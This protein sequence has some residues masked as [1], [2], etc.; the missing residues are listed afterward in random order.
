M[1]VVPD[2]SVI[3]EK[4]LSE[5]I[6]SGKYDG[7]TIIIPEIVLSELE[8]QAN[9]GRQIGF[10]GLEEIKKLRGLEAEGKIKLEYIGERPT[11]EEI[12]LAKAGSLDAIIRDTAQ[13]QGAVLLTAD[14]VQ[15]EVANAKGISCDYV[16]PY[17]E[18]LLVSNYFSEGAQ[19]VHLK[20]GRTPKAKVGLPG[21][22]KL[23]EISGNEIPKDEINKIV[24]NINDHARV[25]GGTEMKMYGASIYQ[26]GEYR[27][28]VTQPPFSERTEI[29]AV[30]PV[31]K[32]AIEDYKLD[33][34]LLERLKAAEGVLVAGPP[35][36]GKSTFVQ[37]VAEMY[38]GMG[39]IVKTMEHPRDLQV[40]PD[41]TQ[42]SALEGNMAKT[43]DILLLVRPDYTVFDELRKTADF[44]TYADLR[45]A[46]VGMVGV[47]HARKPIDA[48]Q[49]LIGRVELG[50]IPQLVDTIIHIEKGAAGKVLSLKF[51]VKVPNGMTEQDLARP[52]IEVSDFGTGKV[53]Y[54]IYSYGEEV[55]VMPVEKR[56][57]GGV[58]KIVE[59]KL[60]DEIRGYTRNFR[61]DAVS[62]SLAEVY[63]PEHVMAQII[64]RE[65]SNI[66][67][68]EKKFGIRI[69]LKPVTSAEK[70]VE[71]DV[72]ETSGN[73]VISVGKGLAGKR[74]NVYA[75][76]GLVLSALVGSKG[77]IKVRKR[78]KE[79]K[80][81]LRSEAEVRIEET[82]A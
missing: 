60:A 6:S 50:V 16:E 14:I 37:A 4:K 76:R 44:E 74:A 27:I 8:G 65:G 75:G 71:Y 53:E 70:S 35:G 56:E 24:K 46:G 79:G 3:I 43:A 34:G 22:T 48:I 66:S 58:Q 64:G 73:L 69:N 41:I 40:S 13:K 2:T 45:L 36:S 32:L 21:E 39:K 19:S 80:R 67:R 31:K 5:L 25:S 26:L 52:V 33:K 9:R 77:E 82:S 38:L 57:K 81:I 72:K 78:S 51:T 29:T 59:E 62:P 63:V 54:E 1:K 42:Y 23:V 68:I 20:E 49:R 15:A 47:V 7:A 12:R 18:K 17:I 28:A 10:E 55:V 11:A 30:R 61:V